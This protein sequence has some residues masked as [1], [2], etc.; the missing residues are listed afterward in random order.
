MAN[1]PN[2]FP[3]FTPLDKATFDQMI[4]KIE[5]YLANLSS[6]LGIDD[7]EITGITDVLIEVIE[8]VE[9]RRIYFHIFYDGCEMGELNEGALLCF[10]IV[11]LHPFCH[12]SIDSYKLNAKIAICLFI[13]AIYYHSQETKKNK[14]IPAHFIDDLYYSLLYRDISKESLMILAECFISKE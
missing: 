14:R 2:D 13:N 9:K 10:W 8:R 3:K 6:F 4:N 7:D 5:K 12:P 11:K 1:I